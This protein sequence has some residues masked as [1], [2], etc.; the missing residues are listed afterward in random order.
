MKRKHL[1]LK[2]FAVSHGTQKLI[3]AAAFAT[4]YF[5]YFIATQ[6]YDSKNTFWTKGS[7]NKKM[8]KF[9]T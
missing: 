3:G 7:T 8:V 1:H 5:Y 2:L 4:T 9:R 6:K